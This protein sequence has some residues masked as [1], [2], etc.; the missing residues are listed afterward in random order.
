[1]TKKRFKPEIRKDMIIKVALALAVQHGYRQIT[2]D[3]IADALD[4]SGTTI[5]YHF[6]TM[7]QLRREIMRAAIKQKQFAVIAQGL[8]IKDPLTGK[9]S[10]ELKRETISWI[11]ATI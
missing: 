9:M 8:G 6:K 10:D 7:N 11:A 1:M 2:R 5:H 3:Q 4:I